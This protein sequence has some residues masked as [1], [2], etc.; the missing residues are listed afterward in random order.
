MSLEAELRKLETN[1]SGVGGHEAAA[2]RRVRRRPQ[3]RGDRGAG[4][5]PA[6]DPDDRP[7]RHQ[8]RSRRRSTTPIPGNDDAMRSCEVVIRAIGGAAAEARSMFLKEEQVRLEAEEKARRE[9]EEK[10]RLE[11]EEQ[12]KREAEE[13][14]KREAEEQARREAASNRASRRPA[15]AAGRSGRTAGR[16]H[17]PS[18][19]T[20]AHGRRAMSISARR[21]QGAARPHGRRHDGVQARARGGRRRRRQGGR[22]PAR[23]GAGEGGEARR[24]RGGRGRRV[25]LR[26]LQRTASA[27]SSR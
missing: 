6:R 26:A 18:P 16:E 15:R 25:P 4:G 13:Q 21:R 9:A 8:L 7:R 27:R 2:R 1:L 17:R 14:A 22:D 20:P 5:A 19:R 12:A 3:G 23:Q 24:A 11:A 10:A